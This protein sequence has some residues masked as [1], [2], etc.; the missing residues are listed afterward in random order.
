MAKNR[1][2]MFELH[3]N[4][5]GD[6]MLLVC[7]VCGPDYSYQPV[8]NTGIVNLEDLLVESYRHAREKHLQTRN[9]E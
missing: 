1:R 4:K 9:N 5:S 7:T 2:S 3:V 6:Y 8:M